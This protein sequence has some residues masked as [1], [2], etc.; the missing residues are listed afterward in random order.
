[1]GLAWLGQACI[2]TSQSSSSNGVN[3]TVSGANV[4][5][6]TSTEWQVIAHEVGHTFGAVHDCV[7]STCNDGTTVNA[8]QCCP[9]STSTCDA[10]GQ[11]IMNPATSP[12]IQK[13]SPCSIGNICSAIGRNSVK[14]SCLISN[15]NVPTISDSQ[16][17]NG[18]V[19]TGEDCDC[20]GEQ[21]CGNNPC[22]DAKTCKFKTSAVCD[23][24]NE[25]CCSSQCQFSSSGTVCRASTGQ[26]DPQETCSGTSALCPADTTTSDGEYS[27]S[28]P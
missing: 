2:T 21:G 17:G 12:A 14:T 22:C 15:K 23:P 8:Q 10:G 28:L 26:C 19:E 27:F 5:V 6:K 13:F 4:I 18:I 1:V 24:S 25:D 3:E 20:G 11:F 16:C 9:L 7:A